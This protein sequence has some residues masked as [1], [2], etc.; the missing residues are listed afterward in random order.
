MA[1]DL[2][3]ALKVSHPTAQSGY[4]YILFPEHVLSWESGDEAHVQ[5]GHSCGG[6]QVTL[7]QST[8]VGPVAD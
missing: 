8:R 4:L 3:L 5:Q 7:C 2:K 1:V 6:L